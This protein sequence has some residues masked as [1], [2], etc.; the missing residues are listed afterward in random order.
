MKIQ[1]YSN[2]QYRA[3]NYAANN[4]SAAPSFGAGANV[5]TARKVFEQVG[6]AC[7]IEPNGSLTRLMFFIVGTFF[8]LGGRFFESRD[9][10][11][12]REVVTRDV[13]AVA[14]SCAGA[15]LL[16]K[17]AAYG[18]SKLT[19]VP[20][21]NAG[22]AESPLFKFGKDKATGEYAHKYGK[23]G[24]MLSSNFASQKQIIDWYSDFT[25][26]D[27]PVVNLS[28]TVNKNGGSL[29][30]VFKK[31]GLTDKL[32]AISGSVKNDEILEALKKSQ[33]EGSESF[34]ELEAALKNTANDNKLLQFAKKSHAYVKLGGIAFMAATLGYFLPRL[35][36]ITTKKKYQKK[37]EE[38]KINQE[39]FEKRMMRTSPV[40]RVSSGV[41]SFHKA[42]AIKTFK[43]LLSMTDPSA[44]FE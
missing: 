30:K 16:N 8:M 28:E 41:L 6:N 10:D 7:N 32:K 42:S 15:P 13:P 21:V 35:N 44:H 2:N 39:T 3:N 25:T 20:I 18:V 24:K 1:A 43:N 34:K 5:S 40:F 11:E 36:I 31:L 37:L 12:K 38:G 4:T 23:Q 9:N 19:G 27:N 33:A 14:L 22:N 26:L 17:A 29:S